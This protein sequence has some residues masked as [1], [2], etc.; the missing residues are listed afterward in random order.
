MNNISN[1]DHLTRMTRRREFDDGLIDFVYGGIFLVL[2]LAGGL[3]FSATGLRW[4][5]TALLYSREITII[6]LIGVVSF[7]I[8][9]ISGGRRIVE[10][11]RRTM[12]WKERG[13]VK[14]LRWQVSW[15]I[16][17]LASAFAILM[18]IMAAWLMVRGL[19]ALEIFLR[20]FI[21]SMG[22]ATGIVYFGVGYELRLA[23][24]KWVGIVGALSSAL[25][26][27]L[28]TSFSVSWLIF[29]IAWMVVLTISG[30]WA[31]RQSLQAL[32][33]RNSD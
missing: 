9:F 24:Y 33:E 21:A 5:V 14:S 25:I 10:R 12:I 22:I 4:L 17:L 20:A 19:I 8:L 27:I 7:V 28:P 32:E 2:S 15:P 30:L 1:L 23:R 29:G 26:L 11:I 31:L 18:I 16:N 3:F 13:F 6:G